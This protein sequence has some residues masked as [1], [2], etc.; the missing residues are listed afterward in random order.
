MVKPQARTRIPLHRPSWD[1]LRRSDPPVVVAMERRRSARHYAGN[2]VTAAQLGELLFRTARVRS[3]ISATPGG[4]GL[5]QAARALPTPAED[6]PY[7]N[8]PYP[9]GGAN[10]EL[11]LY[12]TVSN[13]L[14]LANGVYHYDPLGHQLEPVAADGMAAQELLSAARRSAALGSPAQVLISMTARI[15]RLSW[16]YEGLAYRLVL[17]HVGVLMQSLYIACTAMGLA[18]CALDAV[19]IDVAAR[20]FGTDWRSEP[21]MG[22]FLVGGTPGCTQDGSCDG[23]PGGTQGSSPGT[24]PGAAPGGGEALLSRVLLE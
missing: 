17:M 19:D 10:Y 18:P 11:E 9:S 13:C 8:R 12:L 7:S 22:Q 24:I 4:R 20:A 1:E 14:G 23:S 2:P 3:L 5:R 6:T 21:C 15:R 16:R